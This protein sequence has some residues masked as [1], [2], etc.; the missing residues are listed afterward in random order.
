MVLYF[1]FFSWTNPAQYHWW[2]FSWGQFL[3]AQ[4]QWWLQL[5]TVP[6]APS[7]LW[8]LS[9]AGFVQFSGNTKPIWPKCK[10]QLP[11]QARCA[12][13]YHCIILTGEPVR[14]TLCLM[15]V[16]S[17]LS[18]PT[19]CTSPC[20]FWKSCFFLFSCNCFTHTHSYIY[21]YSLFIS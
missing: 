6:S 12:A 7:A 8:P 2:L 9:A 5:G 10:Q 14:R 13:P 17:L 15:S 1:L 3:L 19:P 18:L 20:S 16:P 11:S 4:C 21:K